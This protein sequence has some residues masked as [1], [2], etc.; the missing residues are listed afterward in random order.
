MANKEESFEEFQQLPEEFSDHLSIINIRT[1]A[2]PYTSFWVFHVSIKRR[3]RRVSCE[4]S[5]NIWY[6]PIDFR[7]F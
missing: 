4:S 6:A 1:Q 7:S 5:G 3:E 2:I